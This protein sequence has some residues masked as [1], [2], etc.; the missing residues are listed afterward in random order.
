MK[1]D[2]IKEVIN[3]LEEN[4]C[5]DEEA[6]KSFVNLVMDKTT[7]SLL[8]EV[9]KQL[10]NEFETG[11]LKHDFIISP[12]Y[13]LELKLKEAEQNFSKSNETSHRDDNEQYSN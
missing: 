13:Y 8:E 1:D 10:K 6:I 9:K 11:T 3:W 5:E 2:I 12:D 7:E 4:E